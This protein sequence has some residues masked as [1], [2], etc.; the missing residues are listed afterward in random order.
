MQTISVAIIFDS[1]ERPDTTGLYFKKAFEQLNFSVTHYNSDSY[2]S[3]SIPDIY[4]LHICIDDGL[5]RNRPLHKYKKGINIFY[6][7]DTHLTFDSK[8][9]KAEQ[10]DYTFC[11][12]EDGARRMRNLGFNS[13]WLPLGFDED[14]HRKYE[15]EK[16]FDLSFVGNLNACG[17]KER[18]KLVKRYQGN[19]RTYFGKAPFN[20]I[21]KIYSE[22]KIVLNLPVR[23]DINMRFFEA[24]GSGSFLLTKRVNNG[25]KYIAQEGKHYVSFTNW[26]D[27]DKK[28]Q[29]YLK[30]EEK[31]E[32]I[33]KEGYRIALAKFTYIKRITRMFDILHLDD[34]H[35]ERLAL[36][37]YCIGRGIEVGCGHRKTLT[38]CIG[39]DLIAKGQ[40]GK[41]GCVRNRSSAADIQASG[42]NLYMFKDGELD[43]IISRHN[44][45]H[46]IDVVKTLVEWKRILKKGGTLGIV[47]PDENKINT[48]SLDPTHRHV[49]TPESFKRMLELIG[50]FEIIE[51]RTVIPNWS[52]M[53]VAEKK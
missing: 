45:E 1:K 38:N 40:M 25:E 36:L 11:A 29:Y 12:Q 50:E 14:I 33:A 37:P 30:N 17:S 20:Q 34:F 28:I 16:R 22:S 13:F 5:D 24:L 15:N 27:L 18:S 31:R 35:P 3:D 8:V 23:N 47:L 46:Y 48:I 7:I 49:F 51:L 53:C 43:Y 52:F 26:W 9:S 42:D 44:L 2:L 6:A 21:S 39:I 32:E 41:Y 4:D 19:Y 10:F